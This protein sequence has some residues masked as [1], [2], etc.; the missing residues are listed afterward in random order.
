[1]TQAC[2]ADHSGVEVVAQRRMGRGFWRAWVPP[3]AVL[4]W[5][6]RDG[7]FSFSAEMFIGVCITV[8]SLFPGFLWAY[9]GTR[10]LPAFPLFCLAHFP[11]YGYPILIGKPA[12]MA[13]PR[14]ARLLAGMN[15]VAFLCVAYLLYYYPGRKRGGTVNGASNAGCRRIPADVARTLFTS[16]LA[17]WLLIMIGRNFGWLSVLGRWLNVAW[18]LGSAAGIVSIFFL[19]RLRGAGLLSGDHS[20]WVIVLVVAGSLVS[21]ASGLL[22]GGAFVMIVALMGYAL[23]RGR[24]PWGMA[25]VCLA[26]V[27]FLNAGKGEMRHRFWKGRYPGVTLSV[28]KTIDI[29]AYWIP[30]SW[31]RMWQSGKYEVKRQTI[32]DRASLIQMQARVTHQSPGRR[33]F[34]LGKTYRHI[35]AL[36]VPRFVWPGKPHGHISTEMLGLYYGVHTRESARYTSIGF[37]FL[38]EA[39]ANFGWPGVIG[40]GVF[41]GWTMRWVARMSHGLPPTALLSV[42]SVVWLAWSFR[43]ESAM[44]SWLVSMVQTLAMAAVVVYPFTYRSRSAHAL[45]MRYGAGGVEAPPGALL[46]HE[47]ES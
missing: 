12:Y 30:A 8:L 26:L 40:L 7:S 47:Q 17:L 3:V 22:V 37:G 31:R 5:V 44:S 13:Y 9:R 16:C 29:Y 38:A 14:E 10:E 23:G 32:L 36:L 2:E 11:Y 21:F 35:P 33:P 24:I 46:I 27:T 28:N 18:A 15:V 39:W 42:L 45:P 20:V 19:F 4:L 25:F 41:F 1:M 6:F 43:F 34:L